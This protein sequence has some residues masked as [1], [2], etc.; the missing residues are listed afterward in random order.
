VIADLDS[1][2]PKIA[3]GQPDVIAVSRK[4]FLVQKGR[5]L[6]VPPNM[7]SSPD[8]GLMMQTK[9]SLTTTF[10]SPLCIGRFTSSLFQRSLDHIINDGL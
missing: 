7:T 8:E 9:A 5:E 6:S 4:V 2:T 1:V 3:S 10:Q